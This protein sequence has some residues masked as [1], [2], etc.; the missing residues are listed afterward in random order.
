MFFFFCGEDY[1][2]QTLLG[3][4]EKKTKWYI[5]IWESF[6]PTIYGGS[7]IFPSISWLKLIKIA[8]GHESHIFSIN[9]PAINIHI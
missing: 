6:S 1:S 7:S 9:F 5:Y 2:N 4:S 3:K 8:M